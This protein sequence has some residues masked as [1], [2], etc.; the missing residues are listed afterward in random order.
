VAHEGAAFR[1]ELFL[2]ARD[3]WRCVALGLLDE[4]SMLRVLDGCVW[5]VWAA[6]PDDRDHVIV[7]EEAQ[8]AAAGSP[9]ELTGSTRVL[10]P[11]IDPGRTFLRTGEA[12]AQVAAE[13]EALTSEDDPAGRTT[14]GN[15]AVADVTDGEQAPEIIPPCPAGVDP[16]GWRVEYRKAV[17]RD[18]VRAYRAAEGAPEFLRVR[19]SR[20]KERP[21]VSYL[22]PGMLTRNGLACLFGASMS[23][24]TYFILDIGLT[25]ATGRQ[26]R[27]HRLVNADG[28]PGMVHYVMAEG[29]DTNNLRIDAWLYHHGL[30]NDDIEDT[31][32]Y[33]PQKVMLTEAGIQPY[34]KDVREDKPDLIILDT[35]NLMFAGRESQ[36][37]DY[38][39]MLNALHILQREA[40]GCCIVLIDH[41]GLNNDDR[42][43]GNNAQQGGMDTEI[44]VSDEDG[45]R[46]AE[47]TKDRSA[48]LGT[49]WHYR[50]LQ[51]PEVSREAHVEAPAVVVEAEREVFISA[52]DWWLDELPENLAE[53][54]GK[55]TGEGKR[56]ALDVV[57]VLRKARVE[58]GLTRPQ[59]FTLVSE[60]PGGV[61]ARRGRPA[62]P[63]HS[64]S[65]VFAAVTLLIDIAAVETTG[66]G[67]VALAPDWR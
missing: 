49:Y 19:A 50:L 37:E 21:R 48:P 7:Y 45:L 62:K 27:G 63:V 16:A 20:R 52:P 14:H 51:I 31:F 35:R 39:E 30:T 5:R 54:V 38:A 46:T 59:I 67:K 24:K 25:F 4:G 43:R 61:P 64:R 58:E 33:F 13:G 26:W 1:H 15:L 29:E 22:V 12:A 28:T 23:G 55:A 41:I 34:L 56:S 65:S 18:A 60:K 40:G 44:K 17:V 66:G 53:R 3:G 6:E 36:G 10:G 11:H 47:V 9:W 8:P 32:F 2:A 42:P 57:R